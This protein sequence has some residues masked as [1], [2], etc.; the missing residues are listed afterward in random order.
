MPHLIAIEYSEAQRRQIGEKLRELAKN[1]W[2]LNGK[3]DAHTFE[4]WPKLF[5]NVITPGLFVEREAIVVEN[6]E[7]L[8]E[9]PD[10]L[11]QF[12]E[13]DKADTVILLVFNTDAKNLKPVK[14]SITLIKPEPQIAPWDRPKWLMTLAKESKFTLASDAAQLLADSV[15]SQE[16]LRSEINKLALYSEGREIKLEDVE[17]LCFDEGGRAMNILLDNV[18]RENHD[19]VAR[20]L[21]YLRNTDSIL[22]ILSAMTNR[23]RIALML[24]CFKNANEAVK[25]L[26]SRP[27]AVNLARTALKN[28]GADRIKTFIAKSI[29]LSFLEKT[30]RSEGWQGFELI[31]WELMSKI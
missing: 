18:C 23:L 5:E 20:A 29:R 30:N 7:T 14:D 28:F 27:Y 19:E 12:L 9:F 31:I 10:E 21:K 26:G 22:P 2:S 4:A 6:A 17:T 16:E 24:S 11:A 3:Y 8:G 1:G 13:N 15:D 25:L